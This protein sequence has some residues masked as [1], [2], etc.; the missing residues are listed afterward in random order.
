M[1]CCIYSSPCF[2][3]KQTVLLNAKPVSLN[4]AIVAANY[5]IL[6]IEINDY[7]EIS[8]ALELLLT[9][10][11]ILLKV[12]KKKRVAEID[13]RP[14]IYSL[15]SSSYIIVELIFPSGISLP[16]PWG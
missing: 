10:Q 14:L 5:S 9:K 2:L 7:D 3:I 4:A 1:I 16:C 6:P 15:T 11:T 13:I 8:K 12:Q